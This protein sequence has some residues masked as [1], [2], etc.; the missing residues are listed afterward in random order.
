V[1]LPAGVRAPVGK[2]APKPAAGRARKGA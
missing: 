1:A 2:S